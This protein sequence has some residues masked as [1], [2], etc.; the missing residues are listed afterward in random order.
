MQQHRTCSSNLYS[1]S[2]HPPWVFVFESCCLDIIMCSEIIAELT[3][4]KSEGHFNDQPWLCVS[5]S[6]CSLLINF[7]AL[8]SSHHAPSA[9]IPHFCPNGDMLVLAVPKVYF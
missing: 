8:S 9:V 6:N 1:F 3:K 4:Q 5:K 2:L 7:N